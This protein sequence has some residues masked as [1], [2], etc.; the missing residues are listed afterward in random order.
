ML[1]GLSHDAVDSNKERSGR[2]C[3]GDDGLA[4]PVSKGA[5][6]SVVG[7]DPDPTSSTKRKPGR[8]RM[9]TGERQVLLKFT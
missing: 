5:Y 1:T 4:L 7:V 8:R 9:S 2:S 6:I 3:D